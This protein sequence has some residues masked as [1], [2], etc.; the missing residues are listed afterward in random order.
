[1]KWGEINDIKKELVMAGFDLQDS[2][3]CD[4]NSPILKRVRLVDFICETYYKLV[5]NPTQYNNVYIVIPRGELAQDS[6]ND[7]LNLKYGTLCLD[8]PNTIFIHP[9]HK[10]LG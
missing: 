6:L 1:M 9:T 5:E 2:A 8:D 4:E 10:L 7:I 3:S